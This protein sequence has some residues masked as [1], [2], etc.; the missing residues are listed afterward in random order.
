[1]FLNKKKK[2]KKRLKTIPKKRSGLTKT[3]LVVN[4]LFSIT[5]IINGLRQVVMFVLPIDDLISCKNFLSYIFEVSIAVLSLNASV[6]FFIFVCCNKL[7]RQQVIELWENIKFTKN[8]TRNHFTSQNQPEC[9]SIERE[10]SK[11]K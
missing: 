10:I 2:K 4:L 1:M 9:I 7:F 11:Y 5:L 3:I 6:N 8:N